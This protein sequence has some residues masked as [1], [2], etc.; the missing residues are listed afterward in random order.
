MKRAQMDL[1]GHFIQR[2]LGFEI[3]PD[4]CNCFSYPVE[5]GFVLFFHNKLNTPKLARLATNFNPKLA[6]FLFTT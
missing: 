6:H 3:S 5:I 2:R 1:P 4:E